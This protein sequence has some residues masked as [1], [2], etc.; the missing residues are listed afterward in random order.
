MFYDLDKFLGEIDV[1]DVVEDFAFGFVF[2]GGREQTEFDFLDNTKI[3]LKF[4]Y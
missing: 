1:A 3:K 4:R 2:D